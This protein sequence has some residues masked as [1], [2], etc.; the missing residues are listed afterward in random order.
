MYT[1]LST[2]IDT[3]TLIEIEI[4]LIYFNVLPP[5]VNREIGIQKSAIPNLVIVMEF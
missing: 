5:S 1:G 2:T 4:L 3:I